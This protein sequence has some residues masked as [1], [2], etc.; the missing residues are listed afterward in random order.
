M[1]PTLSICIP[2][3]NR[4]YY[5]EKM[6]DRFLEDK[7]LFEEKIYLYVSDNCSDE[8]L[9]SIV[10]ARVEKGL[11]VHYHRNEE[12]IGGDKNIQACFHAGRGKYTWGL[13]SDDIIAHGFIR[14]LLLVLEGGS[15]GMINLDCTKDSGMKVYTDAQ[16]FLR[17]AHIRMTSISN[18]IVAT[19]YI[20]SIDLAPYVSSG[21]SQVLLYT[22]AA[23]SSPA[24]LRFYYRGFIE[25][26]HD[27]KCFF[28]PFQVFGTNLLKMFDVAR[29]EGWINRKSYLHIKRC[30]YRYPLLGNIFTLLILRSNR[31]IKCDRKAAWKMLWK[32]YS[33]CLY[34]Y[35]LF[36]VKLVVSVWNIIFDKTLG[37]KWLRIKPINVFEDYD[38][39]R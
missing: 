28:D 15:Y 17:A 29:Q 3:Y 16:S 32:N 31:D 35:L 7:D 10:D 18:V 12:N 38:R 27:K 39:R 11:N 2:I 36:L 6:L 37:L 26:D 19:P 4:S 22:K 14:K 20:S 21:M 1:E 13:G 33:Y 9:K 23:C 24:N 25:E 30:A 8:D 34:A 5:L